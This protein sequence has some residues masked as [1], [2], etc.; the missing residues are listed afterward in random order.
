TVEVG[1]TVAYIET[2][3]EVFARRGD[4]S[5][6]P[7]AEPVAG[8]A[9]EAASLVA[10]RAPGGSAAS[11]LR[12]DE[13]AT[14]AP[15]TTGVE[16]A[17]ERLRRRSTPLVRRIAAE[18][19]LSVEDVPG[20][21]RAGRVTKEDVLRFVAGRLDG[22]GRRTA[23]AGAAEGDFYTDVVHPEVEKRPG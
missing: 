21:G 19:G 13:S 2:D 11:G 4:D 20:T 23:A 7:D 15:S 22:R 16:T 18:H 12:G 9:V 6:A 17:E 3:A 5:A 10:E 8:D 14:K 1:T